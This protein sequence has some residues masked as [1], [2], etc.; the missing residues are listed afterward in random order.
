VKDDQIE[1]TV[2][3]QVVRAKD[4]TWELIVKFSGLESN[5]DAEDMA[6][7]VYEALDGMSAE[8]KTIH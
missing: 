4:G 2:T 3:Q 7:Y 6:N 8:T 1:S 5:D